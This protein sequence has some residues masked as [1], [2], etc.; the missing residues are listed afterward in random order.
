[1]HHEDVSLFNVEA[2]G[3]NYNKNFGFCKAL[4]G[5]GGKRC[6]TAVNLDAFLENDLLWAEDDETSDVSG[7]KYTATKSG[8]SDVIHEVRVYKKGF[9][10]WLRMLVNEV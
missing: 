10:E 5:T 8:I 2:I 1:M 6:K 9:V 4:G 7:K 3:Q